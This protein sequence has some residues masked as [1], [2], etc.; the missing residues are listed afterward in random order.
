[1]GLLRLIWALNVVIAH[2]GILFKFVSVGGMIAVQIFFMISGFYM[3]L[4]LSEKYVSQKNAHF[5][6]L[7]NRILRLFSIKL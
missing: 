6:F 1:M 4:I 2:T 5:L 7:S 3:S